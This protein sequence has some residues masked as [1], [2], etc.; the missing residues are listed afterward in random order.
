[1]QSILVVDDEHSMRDVIEAAL[2][3]DYTVTCVADGKK[4]LDTFARQDF[5]LIITDVLMPEMDGIELLLAMRKVRP[6]QRFIAISGGSEIEGR[7][8][9]LRAAEL[10]GRCAG[11]R[12]PFSVI[13][14][15]VLVCAVLANRDERLDRSACA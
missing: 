13:E 8:D 11:L 4:A 5:D 1:M 6:G 14:L 2:S 3:G 9:S 12:K 10:L 7:F 15:R